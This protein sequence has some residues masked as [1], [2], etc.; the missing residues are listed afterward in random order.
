M[1]TRRRM[2]RKTT[3]M[4][5]KMVQMNIHELTQ[6]HLGAETPAI[7]CSLNHVLSACSKLYGVPV[8]KLFHLHHAFIY[9][10]IQEAE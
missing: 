4:T 6:I 3:K 2:R 9:F 7:T 8:Y 5:S 1:T 10:S